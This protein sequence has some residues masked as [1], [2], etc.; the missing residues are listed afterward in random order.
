MYAVFSW[1]VLGVW[2]G[3]VLPVRGG[4]LRTGK[5]RHRLSCLPVGDD[6][7]YRSHD[8]PRLWSGHVRCRHD[9]RELRAWNL[10]AG[11][12]VEQL[13]TLR[14]RNVGGGCRGRELFG[15]RIRHLCERRRVRGLRELRQ[16][17]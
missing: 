5:R 8:V 16:L 7:R 10:C 3:D 9:L 13:R 4:N 15:L 2:V 11:Q 17:R 1:N 12:R 14:A 6:L